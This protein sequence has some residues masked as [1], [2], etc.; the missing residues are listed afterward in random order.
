MLPTHT[1]RIGPPQQGAPSCSQGLLFVSSLLLSQW[2]CLL[3][4]SISGSLPFIS[5]SLCLSCLPSILAHFLRSL[6]LSWPTSPLTLPPSHF[7]GLQLV[8][9]S[10]E[11]R[12]LGV[13]TWLFPHLRLRRRPPGRRQAALGR[14]GAVCPSRCPQ[15]ILG[16][17]SYSS[18]SG[19]LF[20]PWLHTGPDQL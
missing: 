9:L 6:F 16:F 3:S 1:L 13:R 17:F 5:L 4:S 18:H 14:F 19:S 10:S 8:L 11:S 20:Q 2:L 12:H 7:S 15:P